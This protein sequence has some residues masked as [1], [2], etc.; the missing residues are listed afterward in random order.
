[1]RTQLFCHGTFFLLLMLAGPAP[2][3]AAQ[4]AANDADKL[5]AEAHRLA[6]SAATL[7]QFT[8]TLR[9]C[10]QALRAN[11]SSETRGYIEKLASWTYNKRGETLIRLAED[12]VELDAKRATQYEQ[13]ATG[14]FD[15]AVKLDQSNWKPR[16]N[17]AVC[18][19][20]VGD[21]EQALTD[22]TIV[23]EEK[24]KHKNARFNRAEILFELGRIEEAVKD[25]DVVIQQDPRD[26]QALSGRGLA[27]LLVQVLL[28]QLQVGFTQGP[29][30]GVQLGQFLQPL[31]QRVVLERKRQFVVMHDVQDDHVLLAV[32]KLAR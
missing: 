30:F 9:V 4:Q 10:Q 7:Q 8:Q 26:L 29:W 17:R 27:L 11:P 15:L 3:L 6:S 1:M 19:A 5:A 16:Y 20:I 12:T 24:P 14:D 32:L 2:Y 31:E 13:A 22:L 25:Y 28:D 23:I 18:V 21:Y